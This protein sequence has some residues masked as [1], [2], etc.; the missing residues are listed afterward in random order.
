MD[1]NNLININGRKGLPRKYKFNY[2]LR[3]TTLFFGVAALIYAFWLIFFKIYA[4][5]PR[6]Y[7]FVPFILIFL[8]ASSIM[9]NLFSLNTILLSRDNVKFKFLGRKSVSIQ[10]GWIY[11]MTFGGRKQRVIN[12]FYRENNTEKKFLLQ[13]AFPNMLEILNSMA[14][15]CED[16]E[17]DDFLESVLIS[18]K[19]KIQSSP[20]N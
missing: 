5:S 12:I 18:D 6:F 16:V 7:K 13:L 19:E 1:T 11:K 15:L 3:W 20:K 14:E 8:S 4:D 9:K 17:Y 2:L 10:W